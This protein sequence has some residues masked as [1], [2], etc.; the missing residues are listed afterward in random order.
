MNYKKITAFAAAF[1]LMGVPATAKLPLS[2]NTV[3]AVE[4]SDIA[5]TINLRL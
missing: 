3:F 5:D 4:S 1:C 2:E